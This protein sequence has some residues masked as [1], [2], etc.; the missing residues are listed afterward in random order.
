MVFFAGMYYESFLDKKC[1]FCPISTSGTINLFTKS[2]V[3]ASEHKNWLLCRQDFAII[4][5]FIVC[6]KI[7][8]TL[9]IREDNNIN[10][11]GVDILH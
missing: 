8:L 5:P 4:L 11:M 1:K 2:A 7:V 3:C 6:H 9:F 10:M